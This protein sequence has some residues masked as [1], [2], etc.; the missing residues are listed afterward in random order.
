[1]DSF[2]ID[3]DELGPMDQQI[4]SGNPMDGIAVLNDFAGAFGEVF[5]AKWRGT[6]VAVKVLKNLSEEQLSSFAVEAS[7]MK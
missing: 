5:V 2:E 7:I 4:G 1:V 6:K 3:Y